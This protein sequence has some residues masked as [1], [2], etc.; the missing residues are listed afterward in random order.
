[1]TGTL[2]LL[3]RGLFDVSHDED[4]RYVRRMTTSQ[5]FRHDLYTDDYC[6]SLTREPIDILD[7]ALMQYEGDTRFSHVDLNWYLPEDVLF[8]VDR[9]SMVHGLEVRVPLLDHKL[10]EWEMSLPLS[11]RF[12]DGHG[13]YLLR[14][15]AARYLPA[16]ILKPRKQGFT[17]PIGAWLRGDLGRW[18]EQLFLSRKFKERGIFESDKVLSLLR[19]HQSGK[20]EL[21][22]R[23]WSL[24]VLEI[25]FRTWI[26]E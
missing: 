19:M 22:H 5:A 13:K 4:A 21:G 7:D 24:M 16:D 11:L 6:A 25:W 14:K 3:Q 20:Y 17:I 10:L 12:K 8:K 2:G 26:D 1:R 9:M 15:V 23:I 18:A